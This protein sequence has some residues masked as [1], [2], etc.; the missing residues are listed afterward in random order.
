M[1][2]RLDSLGSRMENLVILLHTSLCSGFDPYGVSTFFFIIFIEK[3]SFLKKISKSSTVILRN[4]SHKR[5][6]CLKIIMHI[7]P[8]PTA[9]ATEW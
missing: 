6:K 8:T 9:T 4:S 3:K 2:K 5:L 1:F 7:N